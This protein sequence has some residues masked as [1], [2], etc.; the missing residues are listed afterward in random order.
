MPSALSAAITAVRTNGR[1]KARV[2][3]TKL[4]NCAGI[5]VSKVESWIF[6]CS[7]AFSFAHCKQDLSADK[8]C[9]IH[10]V[11]VLQIHLNLF[12]SMQQTDIKVILLVI[13]PLI[14]MTVVKY[15][16]G[17]LIITKELTF[18]YSG[19]NR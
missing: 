15:I 6:V 12:F 2:K 18:I 14:V 10:P 16:V 4:R 8:L 13:H 7:V 5:R 3:V 1:T 11:A 17:L 9:S 19:L